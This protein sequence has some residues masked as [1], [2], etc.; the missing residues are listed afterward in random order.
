MKS[1]DHMKVWFVMK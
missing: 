1:I